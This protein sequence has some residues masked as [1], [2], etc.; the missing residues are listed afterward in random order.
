[1]IELTEARCQGEFQVALRLSDGKEGILDGREVLK[2][3]NRNA[4]QHLIGIPFQYSA[5]Y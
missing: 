4:A 1:M 3:G 5:S 2:L